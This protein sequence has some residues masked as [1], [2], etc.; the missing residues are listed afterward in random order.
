MSQHPLSPQGTTSKIPP[1]TTVRERV[2]DVLRDM[3]VTGQLEAG[4]LLHHGSLANQLGISRTPLREALHTLAAEG[5][6]FFD[7]NNRASVVK[8]GT[9]QLQE[10]YEIRLALEVLAGRHA[11]ELSTPLH[12]NGVQQIVDAM[13]T[14]TDPLEWA[15]QNGAFHS[16]LY[17]ITGNEQLLELIEVMRNR[18][19]LYI[20][21]LARNHLNQEHAS[22]EH[23]QMVDALRN[24][25][26]DEMER[27]IRQHLNATTLI[28]G[29]EMGAT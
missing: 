12:A 4:Q 24:N 9:S 16:E 8:P 1:R 20:T 21:V 3:I 14:I 29:A 18:S 15:N 7:S 6:V 25:S 17:A 27:I 5:L 13:R 22:E 26:P 2:C 28:V 23:Q 10:I 19:K 11:A